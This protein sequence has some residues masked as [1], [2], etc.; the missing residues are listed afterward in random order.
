MFGR[1]DLYY[2]TVSEN[3]SSNGVSYRVTNVS[4]TSTGNEYDF[5]ARI[6]H[7]DYG[8]VEI[9]ATDLVLCDDGGFSSGSIVVT[10][11]TS[12]EVLSLTYSGCDDPVVVVYQGSS[13]NVDQ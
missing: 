1:P 9:V 12:D 2:C 8:Y 4:F 11:S 10:D 5:T 13:Y 6:Y 7:E 3:F